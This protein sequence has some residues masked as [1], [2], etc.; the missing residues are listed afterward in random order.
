MLCRP[1]ATRCSAKT[2]M[3]KVSSCLASKALRIPTAYHM[4]LTLKIESP[5]NEVC[6]KTLFVGLSVFMTSEVLLRDSRWCQRC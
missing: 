2:A 4:R 6:Y 3:S 5:K 1:S